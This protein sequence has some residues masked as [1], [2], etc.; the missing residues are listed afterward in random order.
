MLS[1]PLNAR[2]SQIIIQPVANGW[3]VIMPSTNNDMESI[4]NQFDQML[5]SLKGIVD[6]LRG[7]DNETDRIIRDAERDM[8]REKK[9]AEKAPLIPD[10]SM[11]IF[12]TFEKVLA[13]LQQTVLE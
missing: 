12:D 4:Q 2:P 13:H 7:D 5:P 6:N 8:N 9:R 10:K 3:V 1:I 11:L